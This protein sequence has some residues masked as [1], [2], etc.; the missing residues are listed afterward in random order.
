LKPEQLASLGRV[1]VL[2]T[3]LDNFYSDMDAQNQKGFKLVEQVKPRLVIPTHYGPDAAQLASRRWPAFYSEKG[4][5]SVDRP[6]LP[7]ATTV[8]F[9]GDLAKLLQGTL[10]LPASTF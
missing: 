3:Q 2:L 10:H 1:D 6:G 7:E 4:S 9:M 8:V 5:I